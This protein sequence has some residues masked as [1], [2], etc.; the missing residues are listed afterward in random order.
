M[1][2][3]L[4]Y[5]AAVFLAGMFL[6]AVRVLVL[7]PRIGA[8]GAVLAELPIM[9]AVSWL[10]CARAV[11]LFRVPRRAGHRLAMGGFAF[12]LLM[13]AELALALYSVATSAGDHFA[14]YREPARAIGLA[15]Q[16]A[17]GAMPFL[18]LQLAGNARRQLRSQ[19]T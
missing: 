13:G 8:V 18:R 7:E 5:F 15:G 6:G 14:A 2:A 11:R 16:I 3:G 4:A 19:R 17:F 12:L 1:P 10:A 9:L